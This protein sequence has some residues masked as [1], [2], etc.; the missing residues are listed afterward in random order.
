MKQ[1]SA[2]SLSGTSLAMKSCNGAPSSRLNPRQLPFSSSFVFFSTHANLDLTFSHNVGL[3]LALALVFRLL[4]RDPTSHSVLVAWLCT[5]NLCPPRS[6]FT[7]TT[8]GL[9]RMW[10][11]LIRRLKWTTP[12]GCP[13]VS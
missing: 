3:V 7:V 4:T 6:S 13:H 8:S 1:P 12:E 10:S 2:Q 11:G 9:G 5:A